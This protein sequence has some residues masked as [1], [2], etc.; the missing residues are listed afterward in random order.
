[1]IMASR[2]WWN[3]GIAGTLTGLLIFGELRG[4]D[5]G[6]GMLI[7][8]ESR[9]KDIGMGMLIFV[10]DVQNQA[11]FTPVLNSRV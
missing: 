9:G 1:M 4:R 8:G 6:M 11:T 7:F 10:E 2:A 5:V 3:L